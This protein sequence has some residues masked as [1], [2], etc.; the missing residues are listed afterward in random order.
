M[1]LTLLSTNVGN[2]SALARF[3]SGSGAEATSTRVRLL[4]WGIGLEMWRMHP[5]I[6]VGANNFQVAYP[7]ARARFSAQRLDDPFID[8]NQEKL[9][10]LAHNEYVQILAEL[11]TIGF[12]LFASFTTGLIVV[13]WRVLRRHPRPLAALGAGGGMFAFAL[14]SGASSFSF[15]WMA[16]GLLFFFA[17]ALLTRF[18]SEI[19]RRDEKAIKASHAFSRPVFQGALVLSLVIFCG[20]VAQALNS[21]SHGA[22]AA[23]ADGHRAERLYQAALRWN[24]DDAATH[25]GYGLW[26]FY[27][28]RARE[29][30]PH[31]RYAAANGFNTSGAYAYLAAAEATGDDPHASERTLALAARVY[32][33]SVFIRVR[34]AAALAATGRKEES[35]SEYAAAL[36]IDPRM[37]RGWWHLINYGVDAASAAAQEDSS[38]ILPGQLFPEDGVFA[39]LVESKLRA[40]R[41]QEKSALTITR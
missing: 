10:Q 25:C 8:L 14:S 39:V 29:A 28:G 27:A 36:S 24:P 16:S 11:G 6:G 4:Y 13:F 18:A 7:E 22:A 9:A 3:Q 21:I 33:R 35:E 19:G 12:L 38:I 23:S 1:Q 34:H 30:V 41:E 17:A 37:A 15:R 2:P 26:L 32:P 5:L 31:L 20:A 40:R